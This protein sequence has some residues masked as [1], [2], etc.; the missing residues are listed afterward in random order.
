MCSITG[1][2]SRLISKSC[3]LKVDNSILCWK[4]FILFFHFMLKR[5]LFN[6]IL[7]LAFW[8]I[9][10]ISFSDQYHWEKY[11]TLGIVFRNISNGAKLIGISLGR[12]KNICE[13]HG[14]NPKFSIEGVCRLRTHCARCKALQDE[15]WRR[16]IRRTLGMRTHITA[17][18]SNFQNLSKITFD[19]VKI[20]QQGILKGSCVFFYKILL[21]PPI[22][23]WSPL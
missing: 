19:H 6:N 2:V 23:L 14:V 18:I 16:Y 20:S 7:H 9:S 4:Y 11:K 17:K 12:L 21:F 22:F 15:L 3:W 13:A 10:D 5:E 1:S 8:Y